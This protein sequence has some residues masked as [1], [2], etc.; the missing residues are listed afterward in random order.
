MPANRYRTSEEAKTTQ[1]VAMEQI[2]IKKLT[3]SQYHVNLDSL[4]CSALFACQQIYRSHGEN[5]SNSV[6]VR[7]ALRAFLEKLEATPSRNMEQE[8]VQTMR[9]AKGVL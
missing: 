4:T 2:Q 3:G 7:R 1:G 6:I 5:F 9:A 8:I